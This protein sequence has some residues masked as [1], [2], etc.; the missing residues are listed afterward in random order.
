MTNEEWDA[1]F[2]D[3][4]ASERAIP[5]HERKSILDQFINRVENELHLHWKKVVEF[6]QE[7]FCVDDIC[8]FKIAMKPSID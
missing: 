5:E 2:S 4:D 8:R 3:Y 7:P 6:D 1:L